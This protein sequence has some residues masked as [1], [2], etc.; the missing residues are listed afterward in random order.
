MS[1]IS[2]K[3]PEI[4]S[5]AVWLSFGW[6]NALNLFLFLVR[7]FIV[8]LLTMDLFRCVLLL[9]I[10]IIG[11]GIQ[12]FKNLIDFAD[13]YFD[14][15]L[16]L[17]RQS[18]MQHLKVYS[19]VAI[20]YRTYAAIGKFGS[21]ITITVGGASFVLFLYIVIRTRSKMPLVFILLSIF[22]ALVTVYVQMLVCNFGAYIN[23]KSKNL[24]QK[25]K[26]GLRSIGDL[27]KRKEM[28][29]W[30]RSLQPLAIH[31]DLG[32][33]TLFI[34]DKEGKVFVFRQMLEY[35]TSAILA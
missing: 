13:A 32:E 24:L 2:G 4:Y 29:R 31:V 21:F 10:I 11:L 20:I 3:F 17:G 28:T 22:G 8:L 5:L 33:V 26:K 34:L 1:F 19:H 18:D 30:I 14:R 23:Q 7:Y 12:L 25:Y 27:R 35:A 6:T 9:A 15:V 16:S